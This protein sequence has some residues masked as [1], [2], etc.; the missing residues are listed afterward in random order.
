MH[1]HEALSGVGM[2]LAEGVGF[3]GV[4]RFCEDMEA[5]T[6]GVDPGKCALPLRRRPLSLGLVRVP[7]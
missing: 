3:G 7:V 6:V 4:G 5:F 1:L 2:R